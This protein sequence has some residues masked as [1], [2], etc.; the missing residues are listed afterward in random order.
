[1]ARPYALGLA[2]MIHIG[3]EHSLFTVEPAVAGFNPKD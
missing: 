1:M 3:D 2:N